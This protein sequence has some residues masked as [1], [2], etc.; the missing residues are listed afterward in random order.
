MSKYVYGIDLGT[1]YSCIAYQDEHGRPVVLKNLDGDSTTPSVVQF[2]EEGSVIVG[3]DAKGTSVMYPDHTISFVK[4]LM[5]VQK[6]A[7]QNRAGEYISPEEISSL[8]LAKLAHDAGKMNDDTVVDVVITCPAYFGETERTATKEAGRLAGLNVLAIIEEPTAAAVYYGCTR[9]TEEKTV[10]IYDLGGGTFDI[11]VM[12]IS[13]G[14]I[15]VICTDG[16]HDLGGKNWDDALKRHLIELFTEKTGYDGD[17]DAESLQDL[18]LLVEDIKIALSQKASVK[19]MMSVQGTRTAIEITREEFDDLTIPT[20]LS[21]TLSLTESTIEVAKTKGV[22]KIDEILMVGGSTKMPQ[23]AA[24]IREKFEM[25]PKILEPDE[26]VAKGAAIYAIIMQE[27]N[28][29]P[30]VILDDPNKEVIETITD[31]ATGTT[32]V[33]VEDTVT[34]EREEIVQEQK[35][36]IAPAGGKVKVVSASTKS[37]GLKVIMGDKG[38]RIYNMIVKDNELPIDITEE[39]CTAENNQETVA[40]RIYES[41]ITDKDYEVDEEFFKGEAILTLPANT[42]GSTP[43]MVTMKLTDDGTLKFSGVCMGKDCYG[44]FVSDC[45]LSKEDFEKAQSRVT[46]LMKTF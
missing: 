12:K 37:F 27:G 17:F 32:T 28:P 15:R 25:E 3:K 23:V 40:L 34:G 22:T 21:S 6:V 38:D 26:A 41:T 31:E 44:E 2:P 45:V 35:M 13:D 5:G 16:D 11:T 1:T 36:S 39:F 19:K 18:T 24:A 9:G 33:V 20:L 4:R 8:I 42:P 29:V 43:V 14:E 10:L 46:S 30:S 7:Y